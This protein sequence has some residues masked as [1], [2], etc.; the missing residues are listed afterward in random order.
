MWCY[1]LRYCV[2][3]YSSV[4]E[5]PNP[6]FAIYHKCGESFLQG[7]IVYILHSLPPNSSLRLFFLPAY[8]LFELRTQL[9]SKH[10]EEKQLRRLCCWENMWFLAPAKHIMFDTRAWI[11]DSGYNPIQFRPVKLTHLP[12][13]QSRGEVV[14]VCALACPPTRSVAEVPYSAIQHFCNNRR[15]AQDL[16]WPKQGLGLRCSGNSLVA[17]WVLR[18]EYKENKGKRG[19]TLLMDWWCAT[20]T[21]AGGN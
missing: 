10:R 1:K 20:M 14:H 21:F 8:L 17:S 4:L 13:L 19:L 5:S 18:T 6:I 11:G 7:I 15:L 12:F 3:G 9:R 16:Y 2:R